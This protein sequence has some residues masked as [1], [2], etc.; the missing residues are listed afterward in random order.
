MSSLQ[1]KLLTN[2]YNAIKNLLNNNVHEK[3]Q[4]LLRY[5]TDFRVYINNTLNFDRSRLL[6][7][8]KM[9]HMNNEAKLG[10]FKKNGVIFNK[11]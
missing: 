9:I 10:N 7:I 8:L 6:N 11:T 5:P 4:H 2:I 3:I 1:I